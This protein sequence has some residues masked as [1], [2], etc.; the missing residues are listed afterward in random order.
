MLYMHSIYSDY[1]YKSGTTQIAT[2][3]EEAFAQGYG[4]CQDYSHILISL[5]RMESIPCRYV[6]GMMLGEGLSHAWV[7][8]YSDGKWIAVDPTNDT[9]VKDDHIRIA[10]G[11]DYSDCSI[12]QGLFTGCDGKAKQYQ[13]ICVSVEEI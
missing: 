10:A 3:A 5:L 1:V 2:T 12:N 8:F 9:V 13:N 6:T 4:V 11:R 7:E